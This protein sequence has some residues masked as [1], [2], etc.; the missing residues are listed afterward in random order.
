M[1]IHD[2]GVLTA[3]G[4]RISLLGLAS[5]RPL[6]LIFLRHLGC[7]FCRQHVAEMRDELPHE[8]IVFVT[9]SEPMLTERFKHWMHSPH[10]FLCDPERRLYELFNVPRTTT[11]GFF[12]AQ[13]ARRALKAYR[14]GHRNSLSF[15]DQLQLGGTYILDREG[16]VLAAFPGKDIADNP[17]PETMR[18]LLRAPYPAYLG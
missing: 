10:L 3:D 13:V 11:G 16:D 4:N 5:E 6:A 15:D 1:K 9:M 18:Q 8:N 12:T 17:A 7:I 14:E 2:Y